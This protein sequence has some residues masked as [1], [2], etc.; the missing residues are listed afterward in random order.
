MP[1]CVRAYLRAAGYSTRAPKDMEPRVREWDRWMRAVDEFY[2]YGDTDGLGRVYQVHRWTIMPAMPDS[3]SS[4]RRAVVREK[5]LLLAL[6]YEL[7]A[8][9]FFSP[10]ESA[11]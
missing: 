1:E 11:S 5:V 8:R 9:A 2:D 3:P 4:V 10:Y 6:P 7:R